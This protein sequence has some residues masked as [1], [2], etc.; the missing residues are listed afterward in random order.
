[1]SG[2]Y[3]YISSRYFVALCTFLILGI[4]FELNFFNLFETRDFAGH[5]NKTLHNKEQLADNVI[6]NIGERLEL[7]FDEWLMDESSAIGQMLMKNEIALLIYENDELVY[8]SDNRIVVEEDMLNSELERGMI[9]LGNSWFYSKKSTVSA[10]RFIELILIR[11][12]YR[13]ENQFL[14]NH[15]GIGFPADFNGSILFDEIEGGQSVYN[16]SGEFLF[17]LSEH[18]PDNSKSNPVPAM[19]AYFLA[20][21]SLMLLLNGWLTSVLTVSNK[22][23]VLF[24]FIAL[25]ILIRWLISYLSVPVVFYDSE[26]FMPYHYGL[27][28]IA[29]SLG[30]LFLTSIFILTIVYFVSSNDILNYIKL[31]L[32]NASLKVVIA[33]A[34]LIVG[35]FLVDYIMLSLLD[36]ST[37][38][39]EVNRIFDVSVYS[40][41]GFFSIGF[42]ILTFVL[43]TDA[44]LKSIA[45]QVKLSLFFPWMLIGSIVFFLIQGWSSGSFNWYYV[46]VFPLLIGPLAYIR[47]EQKEL[48]YSYRILI[49][50]VASVYTMLSVLIYGEQKEQQIKEILAL[51]LATEHDYLAEAFLVN[52]E[53]DLHEDE[54]LKEIMNPYNYDIDACYDYLKKN[55]FTGY[56]NKYDMQL[57]SCQ[58]MDSIIL[59]K[60]DVSVG[61]FSFFD[62]IIS[63]KGIVVTDS[64]FYF[65][66]DNNGRITYL[67]RINLSD[68]V[69]EQLMYLEMNSK[70]IS[71]ELGYPELLIE[72]KPG[73]NISPL[74]FSYA[75]YLNGELVT[76][77]GEYLYSLSPALYKKSEGEFATIELDGWEHLVY[78]VNS[79]HTIIVSHPSYSLLDQLILL[80]YIFVFFHV[81]FTLTILL[82]TFPQQI[83]DFRLNIKN[84]IQ[85]SMISVVLLSMVLIGGGT[86]FFNIKQYNNKHLDILSEKIQSVMIELEHKLSGEEELTDDIYD[87]VT[88][89]LI[90]FSNVFYSDINVYTLNGQL[91]SS[92][93]EEIFDQELIGKKMNPEAYRQM[94]YL[95]KANFVHHEK[96]GELDFLS[97]YVPFKNDN[98][99]VLAYLN[100]PYFTKQSLLTKEISGLVT[101]VANI[102]VLLILLTILITV[103]I[104]NK[105]T[106]PLR[107]IQ[108]KLSG[109]K[110]GEQNEIIAY[111]R[112]DEIGKLINDYNRMV[113]EL[114]MSAEL[115]AKSERESAWREMAKQIAHE[116]KNPLTPMRLHIQH[117]QRAIEEKTPDWEERF[118]KVSGILISQIDNLT[119]IATQF[120]K[121][122]NISKVRSEEVDLLILAREIELLFQKDE[123]YNLKLK[124]LSDD[125]VLVHGN[126]EQVQSIIINLVKNAIQSIPEDRNGEVE[127][128]IETIEKRVHIAV[129][130]NGKGIPSD[131]RDKLFQ[132]NFTTK[133]SGM[134][135]GLAIVKSI[136]ESMDGEIGFV[137]S[138][139]EG[140]TFNVDLP[141]ATE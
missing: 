32:R 17:S 133:T 6:V 34:I 12:E 16:V 37:L 72:G 33:V 94:H 46:V 117:L 39:F 105:I 31:N 18:Q 89:Y 80:S 102:Y 27:S 57:F 76:K 74:G 126:K 93:R 100:L 106:R 109:L 82:I 114:S 112:D 28:G 108:E 68:S 62:E 53:K 77:S 49:L 121:F 118:Q 35:F 45:G 64:C 4:L 139:N 84:K 86:I 20:I 48:Q 11:S 85:F 54:Y 96:I 29:P 2:I 69:G 134:G 52:I 36:H 10:F 119:S 60:E 73:D 22:V 104:S 56:W 92:S 30:D 91:L 83:Q 66:D 90:K 24:V 128:S 130:D 65:I 136:V 75:K 26:L 1:M 97:A 8:W 127:L 113:N 43:L 55:Y 19:I 131:L 38:N 44:L 98:N 120:S 95:K 99:K 138:I 129:K 14:Q 79:D 61:C 25:L 81:L 3:K 78:N 5:F 70:L 15:Y 88:Y 137:T 58:E 110:L 103:L 87:Y 116:I 21:V 71:S 140:T 132:P 50:I 51:N 40:V 63:E 122:A 107:L 59:E 47:M 123:K 67:G 135:L 115:L 101:A 13:Y 141:L 41:I 125:S 7:N 124:I 111:N 23:K 42:I 9:Q